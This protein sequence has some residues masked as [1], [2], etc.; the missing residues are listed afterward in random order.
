MKDICKGCI[1]FKDEKCNHPNIKNVPDDIKEFLR[2][3]QLV[4]EMAIFEQIC[5]W[6]EEKVIIN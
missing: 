2:S 3:K 5:E 1:Y 4:P 6:K